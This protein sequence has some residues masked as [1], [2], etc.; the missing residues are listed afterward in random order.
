M[1][2]EKQ[3][4]FKKSQKINNHLQQFKFTIEIH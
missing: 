1:T 3:E 2:L 4:I